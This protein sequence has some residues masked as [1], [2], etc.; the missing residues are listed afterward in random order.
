M[1]RSPNRLL[2]I[3]VGVV[4]LLL[5]GFGFLASSAHAFFGTRGGLLLGVFE[6]NAFQ[7]IIHV[8]FGAALLMAGVSHLRAAKTVN[9][10]VGAACLVLGIVGLY[11]V[12]GPANV[13]ALN[14][15]DQT[16]HFATAVVLLAAGL[17]AD[18]V[19]R[20]AVPLN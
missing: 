12:D 16:L 20:P 11:L 2:A 17:G 19:Q 1:A 14:A 9:T 15:P 4:Y 5:G 6:V 7:N 8:L 13:F 3:V 10:V 18:R